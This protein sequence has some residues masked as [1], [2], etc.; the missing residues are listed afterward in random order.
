MENYNKECPFT[1]RILYFDKN[2]KP[3][4]R[5]KA[6][7]AIERKEDCSTI[8]CMAYKKNKCLLIQSGEKRWKI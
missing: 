2:N 6:V 5:K 1:K 7:I 3:T 4:T 8:Y